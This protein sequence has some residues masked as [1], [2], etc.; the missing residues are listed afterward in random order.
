MENSYLLLLLIKR[1]I[2]LHH[3]ILAI[4]QDIITDY[5]SYK[6]YFA[7]YDEE[8]IMNEYEFKY[9]ISYLSLAGEI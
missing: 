5:N 3:L 1:Q 8:F 6:K 2:D 7:V 4:H 9:L